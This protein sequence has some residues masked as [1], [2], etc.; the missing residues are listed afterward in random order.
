MSI[1]TLW[2]VNIFLIDKELYESILI[3]PKLVLILFVI[4]LFLPTWYLI[5]SHHKFY[6]ATHNQ[7][8]LNV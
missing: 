3:F 2:E 8:I 5:S 6:Q 4:P 1:I 7:I